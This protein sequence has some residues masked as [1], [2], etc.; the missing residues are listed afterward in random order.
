M[1]PCKECPKKEIDKCIQCTTKW[2]RWAEKCL[3]IIA[4]IRQD[5]QSAGQL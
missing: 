3:K 1:K 4:E 2:Q 5:L